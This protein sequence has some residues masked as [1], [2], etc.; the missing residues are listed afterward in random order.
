MDD[1]TLTKVMG[2]AAFYCGIKADKIIH[3]K[4]DVPMEGS[5]LIVFHELVTMFLI[6]GIFF[7]TRPYII[8]HIVV[9]A[10]IFFLWFFF[11]RNCILT[12]M[13]RKLI[14]YTDED[15]ILIYGLETEK[16]MTFVSVVGFALVAGIYKLLVLK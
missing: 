7:Q 10:F 13:K 4:Y 14:P 5:L 16:V 8:F 15:F 3:S 11:E 1:F 2:V 12:I 9:S 6:L